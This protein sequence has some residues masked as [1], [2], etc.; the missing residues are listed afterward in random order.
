MS[1]L[2]QVQAYAAS[3]PESAAL[4]CE[5]KLEG[6]EAE[7]GEGRRACISAA[8]PCIS[9]ARICICAACTCIYTP[10]QHPPQPRV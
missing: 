2:V 6:A 9:V 10:N 3:P 1:V 5:S 8:C 4:Y 7:R